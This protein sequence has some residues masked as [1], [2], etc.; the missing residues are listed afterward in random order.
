M[1]IIGYT[2]EGRGII[3]QRYRNGHAQELIAFVRTNEWICDCGKP[4]CDHMESE[5]APITPLWLLAA[6]GP[7]E[8]TFACLAMVNLLLWM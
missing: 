5:H 1:N 6:A 4:Q 8:W 7:L 3:A 2:A